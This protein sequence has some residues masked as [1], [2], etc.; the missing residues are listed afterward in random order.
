VRLYNLA[1]GTAAANGTI[2]SRLA[3]LVYEVKAVQMPPSI[4]ARHG[5]GLLPHVTDLLQS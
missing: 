5:G 2:A 3:D 4:G 1:T